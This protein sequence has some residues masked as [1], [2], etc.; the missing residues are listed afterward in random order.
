MLRALF[1]KTE[2]LRSQMIVE[3]IY[4]KTEITNGKVVGY[5]HLK[6]LIFSGIPFHTVVVHCNNL[7]SSES[8]NLLSTSL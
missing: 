8:A 3:V 1:V 7:S 4:S 2:I 5:I 6:T